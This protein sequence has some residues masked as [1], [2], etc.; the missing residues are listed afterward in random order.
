MRKN[1]KLKTALLVLLPLALASC[2]GLAKPV[3]VSSKVSPTTTSDPAASVAS[4]VAS[5]PVND[6]IYAI[7]A[8]YVK[9]AIEVGEEPLD[10]QTWLET[11]RGEQGPQGPQGE[12][13][14][15]G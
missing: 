13:G 7:Y 14:T 8:L 11:V 12:Q 6:D 5:D 2:D 10:Y 4:S 9:N 15:Q 3:D 1:N